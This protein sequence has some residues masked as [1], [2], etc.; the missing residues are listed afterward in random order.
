MKYDVIIAGASFAGLTLARRLKGRRVLLLDRQ[1]IGAGQT[2][3]CGTPYGLL[4]ALGAADTAYQTHPNIVVH[5]PDRIVDYKLP[6]L[7]CT[8]DYAELCRHLFHWSGAELVQTLVHGFEDGEI[9]TAAGRFEAPVMV[10]ASGWR[11]VLANSVNAGHLD[12]RYQSFGLETVVPYREEGLH[13][14]L[15]PAVV[16][17]GIGWVF[18]GGAESHIGMGSY[19][20]RSDLKQ[21]LKPFL[22]RFGF[23]DFGERVQGGWLPWGLRRPVAGSLFVV[24]DAAGHCLGFTGEGIRPAM[25]FADAAAS[26]V[27][28]VLD[29]RQSLA[30]G[31][32]AYARFVDRHAWMYRMLANV[33]RAV[34]KLPPRLL[35]PIGSIAAPEAIVAFLMGRYHAWAVPELLV[36]Q[37]A[38][39]PSGKGLG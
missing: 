36:G 17:Q 21:H 9:V 22:K 25:Y 13:F 15:D 37:Q 28:D 38:P 24:G 1:P 10:D 32:D 29:G 19:A 12:R 35:G 4:E 34:V 18:P 14:W 8:F 6:F 2:S 39:A 27:E 33:Q 23:D 7:F 16:P 11:A 26:Y 5:F 31:L 20:G 3:A 30:A